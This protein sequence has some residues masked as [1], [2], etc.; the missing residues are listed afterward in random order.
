MLE[1]NKINKTK[2][3]VIQVKSYLGWRTKFR[4]RVLFL[5][6]T[7]RFIIIIFMLRSHN[8]Y[9]FGVN[10]IN[11]RVWSSSLQTIAT[12]KTIL[13]SECK[14]SELVHNLFKSFRKIF[15]YEIIN[16]LTSCSWGLTWPNLTRHNQC[17]LI[18]WIYWTE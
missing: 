17:K 8:D 15:V 16:G 1:S 9:N 13:G 14:R 6:L 7:V 3:I 10:G 5:S 11:H 2:A 12:E 18:I 4:V